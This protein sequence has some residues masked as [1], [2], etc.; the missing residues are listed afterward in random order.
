MSAGHHGGVTYG[1]YTSNMS[2]SQRPPS[3]M[4]PAAQYQQQQAQQQHHTEFTA[5]MRDRQARGKD[6]Y[7]DSEDSLDAS[8]W[9]SASSSSKRREEPFTVIEKRRTAAQVLD[10]PELLM[11][12]AQRGNDSIPA[13]RLR[14]TRMLCGVEGPEQT[15]R[16]GSS[17]GS[18][19]SGSR[20]HAGGSKSR[21]QTPKRQSSGA[22]SERANM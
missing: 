11:D 12:S 6:P 13:T 14:Y 4:R 18:K 21:T 8:H 10:T 20:R 16:H 7:Q 3:N 15:P 2:G 1:F 17:S 9:A 19:S 22:S 5:E